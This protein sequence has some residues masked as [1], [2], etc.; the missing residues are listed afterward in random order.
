MTAWK[1]LEEHREETAE[2]S[3]KDRWEQQKMAYVKSAGEV[4]GPRKVKKN[5][6][7]ISK[8]SWKLIDE[9]KIT[10][11]V[12]DRQ[13]K[14]RKSRDQIDGWPL[15]IKFKCERGQKEVDGRESRKSAERNRKRK[16][17]GAV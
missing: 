3:I 12:K 9:K 5:K 6:P 11:H 13:H 4:L 14:F 17:E 16:I 8:N 15:S 2:T 7:R 1:K 10:H